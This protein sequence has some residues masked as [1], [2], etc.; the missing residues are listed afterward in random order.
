MHSFGIC[1]NHASSILNNLFS[2]KYVT[3]VWP[4]K[5]LVSLVSEIELSPMQVVLALLGTG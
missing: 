5:I 2:I 3:A 1:T 4:G